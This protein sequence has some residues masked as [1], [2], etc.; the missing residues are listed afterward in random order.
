MR[1]LMTIVFAL[2]LLTSLCL[3][4]QD[5]TQQDNPKSATSAKAAHITGKISDDGKTFVS[6]SDGKSYAINNPDA[7]KGHEGQHVTLKAN[8]SA[9]K[10]SVDIVSLKMA[11]D[12]MKK[13]SSQN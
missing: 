12:T 5:T 6:D 10:N 11:G 3:V 8:V 4:A 7:V 1:K 2:S 9:D 13:D